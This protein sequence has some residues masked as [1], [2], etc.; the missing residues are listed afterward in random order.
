MGREMD[1][2]EHEWGACLLMGGSWNLGKCGHWQDLYRISSHILSHLVPQSSEKR[3]KTI[4]HSFRRLDKPLHGTRRRKVTDSMQLL[5]QC[6]RTVQKVH[7]TALPIWAMLTY[8]H[9]GSL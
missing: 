7:F 8:V 5:G 3:W 1:K 2:K 6:P 9:P 4:N